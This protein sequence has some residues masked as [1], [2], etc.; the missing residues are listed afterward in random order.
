MGSASRRARPQPR[1]VV[2][3]VVVVILMR[4]GPRW[5][6]R[7]MRRVAMAAPPFVDVDT[8]VYEEGA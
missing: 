5:T 2:V 3:V 8:D 6:V 4:I 1:R 7:V